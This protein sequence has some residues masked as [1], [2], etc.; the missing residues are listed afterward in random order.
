MASN[1]EVSKKGPGVLSPDGQFERSEEQLGEGSFKRVYK[2]ID[3]QEGTTV[4]WNEVDIEAVQKS[5]KRRIIDE[6]NILQQVKHERIMDYVASW[7]DKE[8]HRV[9][10]I[11]EILTE[12]TLKEF[13]QRIKTI[14]LRIVRKWC[15]QILE[16]LKRGIVH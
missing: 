7:Y 4:A 10:I 2:A 6:V 12:G 11:T 3:T 15:R 1:A 8:N 13:T 5:E 9:V 16:V 14:R